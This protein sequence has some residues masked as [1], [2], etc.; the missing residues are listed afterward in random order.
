MASRGSAQTD[1]RERGRQRA[2]RHRRV[3]RTE[4]RQP[5]GGDR[6]PSASAATAS[7]LRLVALPGRRPYG[8]GVAL[9][10]LDRPHALARGQRDVARRD[11]VV[12]VDERLAGTLVRPR[13]SAPASRGAV[14]APSTRGGCGGASPTASAPAA[15]PSASASASPKAPRQAPAERRSSERLAGRK[16]CAVS[17]KAMRPRA[18]ACQRD[19]RR[20]AAAH[21]NAVAGYGLAGARPPSA[22][23]LAIS[24]W[25]T[26]RVPYEPTIANWSR[27]QPGEARRLRQR[28]V[29]DRPEIGD[30]R[31]LDAR[32]IR[33][34]A[35]RY[36]ESW[37]VATT[38][39]EPGL[40]P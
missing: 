20:P 33:S 13:P 23:R 28:A 26:R 32:R 21:R 39:R 8:G 19:V 1:R 2:E 17:S 6:L 11:V 18:C 3:R 29:G 37:A 15:K 38:T 14:G 31:D 34:S 9:D 10:V 16:H 27:P 7:A 4:R 22:Q 30:H 5:D 12:E 25:L 24:A 36:A 40:T 35:A